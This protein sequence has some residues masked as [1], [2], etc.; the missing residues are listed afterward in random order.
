MSDQAKLDRGEISR[1][2]ISVSR[3][4]HSLEPRHRAIAGLELTSVFEFEGAIVAYVR[5]GVPMTVSEVSQVDTEVEQKISS[6][7][8][9]IEDS[10]PQAK[11]IQEVMVPSTVISHASAWLPDGSQIIKVQ[12]KDQRKQ[13]SDRLQKIAKRVLGAE[14]YVYPA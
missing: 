7:F 3:A 9:M 14:I 11:R 12:V 8:L 10:A 2:L 1:Q 5:L 4:L 6:R 13:D